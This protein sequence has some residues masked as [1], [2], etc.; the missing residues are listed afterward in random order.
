MRQAGYLHLCRR[1]WMML[2]VNRS[3][4]IVHG[5]RA[6]TGFSVP[7]RQRKEKRKRKRDGFPVSSPPSSLVPSLT[8]LLSV[9]WVVRLVARQRNRHGHEQHKPP[10]RVCGVK[11]SSFCGNALK[12][13]NLRQRR[14]S[15]RLSYFMRSLCMQRVCAFRATSVCARERVC[16][17]VLPRDS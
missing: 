6:T 2:L 13:V 7:D 4:N 17:C 1:A 14:Q 9:S 15:A 10:V 11:H 5:T 12:C 8:A 3:L 16:L